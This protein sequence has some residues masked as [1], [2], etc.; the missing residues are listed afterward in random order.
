M[1]NIFHMDKNNIIDIDK[2]KEIL[3]NY[4]VDFAYLYGSYAEGTNRSWSD[5][6]IALL[7]DDSVDV[8]GYLEVELEI[9]K[10]I[11]A[12]ISP[13]E[14]D[15]RIFNIAPL[16]YKI[17]VVQNGKLIYSKDESKRVNFETSVRSLY[18]DFLPQKQEYRSALFK[19][20]KEGGLLWSTLK[21]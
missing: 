16:N 11:D 13:P 10:K 1:N 9:S 8:S 20:I 5:L 19:G 4:P 2:I 15:V 18:F 6:D 17:Q 7:V 12:V 21:K 14:S 3:I